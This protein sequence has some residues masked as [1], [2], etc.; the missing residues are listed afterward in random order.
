[1]TRSRTP[2]CSGGRGCGACG[3]AGRIRR[4]READAARSDE[5]DDPDPTRVEAHDSGPWDLADSRAEELREER[6]QILDCCA[7]GGAGLSDVAA[8]RLSQIDEE[9]AGLSGQPCPWCGA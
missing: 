5:R 8:A 1:M 4:E 6:S 7:P 3:D 9:L 2:Q